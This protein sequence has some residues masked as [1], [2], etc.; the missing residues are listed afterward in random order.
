M[1]IEL[2]GKSL[3]KVITPCGKMPKGNKYIAGSAHPPFFVPNLAEKG[4]FY[5]E[6][7]WF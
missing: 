1:D 2:H 3:P 7:V 4:I 5:E 6:V